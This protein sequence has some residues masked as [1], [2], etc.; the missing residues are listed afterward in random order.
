VWCAT[1]TLDDTSG[2]DREDPGNHS[3]AIKNETDRG[4]AYSARE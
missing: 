4:R 2:N 1:K 3:R